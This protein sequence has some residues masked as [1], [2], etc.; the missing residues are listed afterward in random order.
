MTQ[1]Q[2]KSFTLWTASTIFVSAFL[3]FQ[4]Q[5]LIS[6]MILP[7]FGGSPAVWSTCMLFFQ[8]VLLAGYAYAHFLTRWLNTRQQIILH[9]TLL[10]LA[11]CTLPIEPG[12]SWRPIDGKHPSWRIF[13]VLAAS[14]GLPY[15]LLSSTGPLVQ[16]W[17]SKLNP[18]R[19]PYRLYALSNV[20][21]LGALLSY[22]F[23]F[24]RYLALPKQDLSWSIG[25]GIFVILICILCHYLWHARHAVSAVTTDP[26]PE[27]KPDKNAIMEPDIVPDWG[28]RLLWLALPSFTSVAFIAVTNHLSQDV[29][30]VPFLWVL[31]LSIYLLTFI[32]CFDGT[33][34]Y[35]R[36]TYLLATIF[37]ILLLC[38]IETIS[39]FDLIARKMQLQT[40]PSQWID[41]SVN[42]VIKTVNNLT[43]KFL[44]KE[45]LPAFKVTSLNY[46]PI[47]QGLLYLSFLFCGSMVCHGELA[48]LKPRKEWLT[49]YFLCLSLGGALGGVFVALICPQI[50]S[51]YAELPLCLSAIFLVASIA[52]GL[53]VLQSLGNNTTLRFSL[54]AFGLAMMGTLS[55]NAAVRHA[56][57][58]WLR[59]F[60]PLSM[61]F[62]GAA[63][64]GG[65]VMTATAQMQKFCAAIAGLFT[66]AGLFGMVLSSAIKSPDDEQI[67]A[68]R[69]FY[70]A[71]QVDVER[72]TAD[73][74][75]GYSLNHGRIQHG[76]QHADEP[77]RRMPT[78]YYAEESGVGLALRHHTQTTNMKVGV[79]GLGTGT[80]A[81]FGNV[82]D[83][84]RFYEIDELVIRMSDEYF[85]YRKESAANAS[86]VVLGDARIQLE[87]ETPQAYDVIAVDAFSGDAIPVHLLTK[88]CMD[89]YKKHMKPNGILAI[90]ISNRYLD[91]HPVVR[92]MAKHAGMQSALVSV[93]LDDAE[94]EQ[95]N[96]SGMPK[97]FDSSWVLVTNNQEFL[98]NEHVQ[99]HLRLDDLETT[100]NLLWTDQFSNL[101]DILDLN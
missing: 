3:L 79:V 84:Y 15:F 61:A 67:A 89:L 37:M 60:V 48:R 2:S 66:I 71:L 55:G 27:K 16:A 95:R 57:V 97:I 4:V 64:A 56:E 29:A 86:T 19:S 40:T 85:S 63:L 43:E 69:S 1:E 18:G 73:E 88:E 28:Y 36:K 32:L 7:W 87:K 77:R 8:M 25:F 24:E 17:F 26:I 35:W 49:E 58:E 53:I 5:P 100:R 83:E 50:F 11:L 92:G 44:Q 33:M 30:A 52:L 62:I 93:S 38:T 68:A 72:N 91:L 31:P 34:W 45:Y 22:P 12:D 21:S 14:V 76:Y 78:T 47:Y 42:P 10:V 99:P 96:D 81:A 80:I 46:S 74:I 70:G 82:G 20:G 101:F 9:V 75:T 13:M 6:R 23:F 98:N 39:A 41:W 51:W 59:W 94:K 90:H 65:I 54:C